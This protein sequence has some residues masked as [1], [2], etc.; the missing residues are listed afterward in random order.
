MPTTTTRKHTRKNNKKTIHLTKK[1][2]SYSGR[3]IL[4]PLN[5]INTKQLVQLAMI[6]KDKEIMKYIGR[7]NTWSI[8]DIKQF[9]KDETIESK[10][11]T[12]KRQYYTFVMLCNSEVC[13]FIAGR[14]N[15]TLLPKDASPYDLLLRMFISRKHSGK[16]FGKLIIKLFISYYSRILRTSK[17]SNTN[18]ITHTIKLISDIDK[19]NIA[20]IKIH[21]ANGFIHT[22]TITYPNKHTYQRYEF[23]I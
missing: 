23:I 14:K 2:T 5:K 22:D 16:G 19:N 13:G 9:M 6:A 1:R 12:Q 18:N 4:V 7:G 10:N 21:T 11:T 3:C 8:A 15:N 17:S 20:S